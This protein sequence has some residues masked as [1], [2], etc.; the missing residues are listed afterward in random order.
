MQ[1]FSTNPFPSGEQEI[2]LKAALFTGQNASDAWIKWNELVDFEAFF[3]SGSFRLMPLVYKNLLPI[4]PELPYLGKLKNIYLQSWYKNQQLFFMGSVLIS[5]LEKNGIRTML[6][7]GAPLSHFAYH[8]KGA[9]PMSDIDVMVPYLQARDAIT[10][11]KSQGWQPEQEEYLEYNLKWGRSMM[12][13]GNDGFEFDLHW[14][15]FFEAHGTS[16]ADDFWNKAIRF[17]LHE[18]KTLSLCHTDNLLHV[19]VHGLHYNPEPP[20]RWIP[21]S[22]L[23]LSNCRKEIDWDYFI[24]QAQK[25]HVV[26]QV[27]EALNYLFHTFHL[28]LPEKMWKELT[29]IRIS[30]NEKILYKNAQ[31]A[32]DEKYGGFISRL[33]KLYLIY[34]RQ[35]S[36]RGFVHL[37]LGFL[38]FLKYR[39]AGKNPFLILWYYVK[40]YIEMLRKK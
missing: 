26:L 4:D 6:L 24:H 35:T 38:K 29:K 15:P 32:E 28:D 16:H 19:F 1:T 13:R 27:R 12:F 17:Q 31:R 37:S 23:L 7:K 9:R 11:L 25:Y 10:L 3:D 33:K 21:D 18:S 34:L 39:I 14:H 8:D 22:M 20:I 30:R 36:D 5:E 40:R 2:L